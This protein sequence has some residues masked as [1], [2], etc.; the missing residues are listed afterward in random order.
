MWLGTWSSG[1][2]PGFPKVVVLV[3]RYGGNIERASF[4]LSRRFASTHTPA[5]LAAFWDRELVQEHARRG[6]ARMIADHEGFVDHVVHHQDMRRPLGRTRRIPEPRLLAALEALPMIDG[7]LFDTRSKM[8][9]VRM[10]ATDVD[11]RHGDGQIV[12]GPGEALL[13]AVAGRSVALDDLRGDGV[14]VV[15]AADR[16]RRYLVELRSASL[17]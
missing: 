7:K 10:V 3:V 11:W 5:E 15:A 9:G 12:E 2:R 17:R 16:R 14:A 13:M 4:E 6:I 1:T 8:E